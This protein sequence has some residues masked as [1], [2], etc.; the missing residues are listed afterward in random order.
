MTDTEDER[1][2]VVDTVT[3]V[4]RMSGG[5]MRREPL[6]NASSNAKFRYQFQ[7]ASFFV[8]TLPLDI[9]HTLWHKVW[10]VM[11]AWGGWCTYMAVPGPPVYL[12]YK[13]VKKAQKH[14]IFDARGRPAR[15]HKF[16]QQRL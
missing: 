10:Q 3:K 12:V 14:V 9:F 15:L 1:G 6:C 16:D 5:H 7:L 11:H 8:R 2:D 13:Y 4:A